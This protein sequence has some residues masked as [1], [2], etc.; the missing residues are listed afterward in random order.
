MKQEMKKQKIVNRFKEDKDWTIAEM[1]ENILT[2]KKPK[3]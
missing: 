3:V 2:G 1:I